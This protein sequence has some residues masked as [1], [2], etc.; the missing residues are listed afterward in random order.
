MK[1]RQFLLAWIIAKFVIFT[2]L[3]TILGVNYLFCKFWYSPRK[4]YQQ[5]EERIEKGTDVDAFDKDG[6]TALMIAAAGGD[7]KIARLLLAKGADINLKAIGSMENTPLHL[8]CFHGYAEM[9]KFLIDNNA[10]CAAYNAYTLLVTPLHFTIHMYNLKDFKDVVQHF[11]DHGANINIPDKKNGYSLLQYAAQSDKG[12]MVRVLQDEFSHLID[13]DFKDKGGENVFERNKGRDV[14]RILKRPPVEVID[15]TINFNEYDKKGFTRPMIYALKGHLSNLKAASERGANLNLRSKTRQ[16]NTALHWAC[17]Y[18]RPK[19]VRLLVEKGADVKVKNYLGATPFQC[20]TGVSNA[21]D[22]KNVARM[23][24]EKGANINEKDEKGNTLLHNVAIF[25][26]HDL[27]KQVT[28]DPYFYK[29]IDFTV[30]NKKNQTPIDI[31]EKRRDK[32]LME[33]LSRFYPARDIS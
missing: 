17:L 6:F 4:M 26:R 22:R 13:F 23:L 24:I 19:S 15:G 29:K 5:V 18:D 30:K 8:A 32:K 12:Y 9:A 1:K 20:I 10:N 7:F 33:M 3:V 25:A 2:V 28:S 31:A 16:G 21:V 14:A 11:V 27:A